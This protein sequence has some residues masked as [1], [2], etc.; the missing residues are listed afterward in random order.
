MRKTVLDT[1]D[2]KA[3]RQT[4]AFTGCSRRAESPVKLAKILEHHDYF[5]AGRSEKAMMARDRRQDAWNRKIERYQARNPSR[6]Y[7][8]M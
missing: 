3:V 7:G 6:G 8:R 5:I 4:I 2:K 1:E